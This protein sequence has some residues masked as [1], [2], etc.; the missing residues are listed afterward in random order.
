[1]VYKRASGEA[2]AMP[3]ELNLRNLLA[4]QHIALAAVLEG[5]ARMAATSSKLY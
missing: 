2:G 4:L 5:G 3:R 1:M